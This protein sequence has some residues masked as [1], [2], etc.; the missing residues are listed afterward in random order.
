M[1][2]FMEKLQVFREAIRANFEVRMIVDI[3]PYVAAKIF[4]VWYP[5]RVY[6]F[7]PSL[8]LVEDNSTCSICI[9]SQLPIQVVF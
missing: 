2:C 6:K 4:R 9:A 7:R 1:H 8:L 3:G 5:T